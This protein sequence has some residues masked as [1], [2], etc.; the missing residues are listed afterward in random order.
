MKDPLEEEH[1]QKFAKDEQTNTMPKDF[2]CS[3]LA[4]TKETHTTHGQLNIEMSV[5]ELTPIGLKIVNWLRAT[6]RSETDFRQKVSEGS[7]S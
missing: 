6:K 7:D 3:T 2:L 4:R 1:C 5:K